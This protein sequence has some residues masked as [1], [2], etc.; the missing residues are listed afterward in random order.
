MCPKR[1]PDSDLVFVYP[2]SDCVEKASKY[3]GC[4]LFSVMHYLLR[5]TINDNPIL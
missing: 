1:A 5:L 4:K 2:L 3:F